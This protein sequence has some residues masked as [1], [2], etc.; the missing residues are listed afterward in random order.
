MAA[1]KRS[2]SFVSAGVAPETFEVVRFKG[3]EALSQLFRFDILLVSKN[4][5]LDFDTLLRN[6]ATFTIRGAGCSVPLHGVLA[7]FEQLQSLGAYAVYRAV[8]VPKVWMLQLLASNHIFLGKDV[9]HFVSSALQAGDLNAGVDYEFRLH[10]AY[11]AWDF[12]VQYNESHLDFVSRW[13]EYYGLYYFFSHSGADKLVITDTVLAHTAMPQGETLYYASASGLDDLAGDTLVK[14]FFHEKIGVA[15]R[16]L[17]KDHNYETPST[18]IDATADV[19]PEGQG[20]LYFYGNHLLNASQAKQQA[21]RRGQ[22]HSCLENV[23]RGMSGVPF[24]RSGYSFKL[25]RSP[26]NA[27]NQAYVTIA[28]EHQGQQYGYLRSG[29]GLSGLE[30]LD[31]ED[32]VGPEYR[33]NFT[34]IPQSVQFRPARATP[35]PRIYGY[36]NASIDAAGSGKYAELDSQGRYKVILPFD[37]SGRAEG[38]ASTWIRMVQPY[39]GNGHGMHF[40]LHKGA[41]VLLTFIDGDPDR[42]IIAGAVPNPATPSLITNANQTMC[43]LTSG[44]QNKIHIEDKDGSQRILFQTP[45]ENS[46]VRMGA[47]N[48]PPSDWDKG[49]DGMHD[50]DDFLGW[51]LNTNKAFNVKAGIFNTIV[52]PGMLADHVLGWEHR[53]TAGLREEAVLGGALALKLSY[54]K[55]IAPLHLEWEG[56]KIK[57][58]KVKTKVKGALLLAAEKSV[59]VAEQEYDVAGKKLS[60]WETTSKASLDKSKAALTETELAQS[61]VALQQEQVKVAGERVDMANTKMLLIQS[62]T[63]TAAEKTVLANNSVQ[64]S[65]NV[66]NLLAEKIQVAQNNT[67]LSQQ[68]TTLCTQETTLAAEHMLL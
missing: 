19:S 1:L 10:G 64:M 29:L 2:F 16:V 3:S 25:E 46:F 48:D 42:P 21:T 35:K 27:L 36:I 59:T 14:S 30:D 7:S 45:T 6:P 39:G 34:C 5:A 49:G 32:E 57:V 8:L 40:P 31:E 28:V 56:I 60:T 65:A 33:N 24:L 37:L 50:S 17:V 67:G 54:N 68:K 18:P 51:K 9:L 22:E 44:G 26:D 38:N 52:M 63:D 62:A 4:Q 11:P 61:K 47:P 20:D 66:T 43:A 58:G 41:E 13:M 55:E 23:Y 53:Q 12:I 15:R